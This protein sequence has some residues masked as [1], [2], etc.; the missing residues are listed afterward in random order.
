MNEQAL[1]R[2]LEQE[3][4]SRVTIKR[5]RRGERRV[6]RRLPAAE[7]ADRRVY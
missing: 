1:L 4:R 3:T 6:L 5:H 7:R 2:M